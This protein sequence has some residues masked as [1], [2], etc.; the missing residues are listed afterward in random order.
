M[1]TWSTAEL[2][3]RYNAAADLL[4]GNLE[5]GRGDRVAI[6]T[7]DGASMTYAD[8]A[9]AANRAGNAL[10]ELGVEMEN[11]VLLAAL[12]GPEFAA[13]FFGAIKLGAVPVPV[14]TNLKP[15]DYVHYLDDSRAKVAVVSAPL[16]GVFREARGQL[17]HLRHLVVAGEAG[18][19]ELSYAEIT[20]A[21][22]GALDP[23]DTTRDDMCFWLYSSGTT[24]LPKGVVHLQHDMRYVVENY[25]KPVL[26]M[27]AS[28]VTFSV[29]KLYF[30]YGLG[31]ALYM[32]FGVGAST[33]LHAGPPAPATV[34][35][36]V[37]H[38]RPTLYFAVPTSYANTLAADPEVWANADFSSVRV[39]VSAG[40]PLAGSLLER[41]RARTGI[42]IL[43]G[44]GSTECGHIF[45]SNRIG[46]VRPDSTGTVVPGYEVRIVDETGADVPPDEVGSLIVKG[47]STCSM[48]WNQHERTKRTI[49]GEWID[50]GDQ[51]LRDADGFYRYQGR[52]DDMLKVSGI[53]VSPT[54][55]EAAINAHQ[56]VLEC[57]VVAVVDEQRLVR[58]EAYVVLQPSR[59][60]GVELEVELREHVRSALAH[61][62]CPRDFHFVSELPKTATGKIQRFKLR[63][64]HRVPA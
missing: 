27:D 33:V 43:D 2:P 11:R 25:A 28:D 20:A 5:A 57:A 39:C 62:K 34:L 16:A 60:A 64:G 26:Q 24:G 38:L 32:P 18:P 8:V 46:E 35:D 44:I 22:A 4:D 54:E 31:N 58:P 56:A 3:E 12:D 15:H 42:D 10:R 55:V 30:A 50:T 14:N 29:A 61:F 47:D 40:E 63:E 13:T 59:S 23:A 9:A 53:W 1:S 6:R 41:W 7:T 48:Y 37:R 45:I 19:D 17:R 51:Y 52:S 49:R 21:A 36:V